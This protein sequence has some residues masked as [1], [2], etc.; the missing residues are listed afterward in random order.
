MKNALFYA[1]NSKSEFSNL[2]IYLDTPMIFALMGMDTP[3]RETSYNTLLTKATN[4][5]MTIRVFDHN[6]EEA[7]GIMERASRCALSGK[8][9]AAKANKVAQFFYESTMSHD[10]IIEFIHDFQRKL[11]SKGISIENTDYVAEENTFQADEE[12]LFQDIKN[13]YGCRS[14]K[15]NSEAEYDNSIRTD[16]RSLVMIQRKRAG[17]YSTDLNNA[18]CIF[19]TTNG[20]VAKVSKDYTLEDEL[21]KDKI[22]TAVTADLFGTLLW[23][24]YP[25]K[26]EY[27]E[28]KL[29][30]DC[31]ALLKASPQMIAR[32][33][34]ELDNAY[35]KKDN[36]LTEEKFLFLQLAEI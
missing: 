25:D 11:N 31:K 3:E 1:S 15:Y 14:L 33:N 30:A 8:Y 5:G 34:I 29:I 4:I 10:E 18:R 17:V 20:V 22:P 27:I 23:M 28:Q 9:D 13:E 26:N 32:F 19:I 24:N 36:G 35:Q 16:V 21:T 6:F 12:K 7:K 2:V